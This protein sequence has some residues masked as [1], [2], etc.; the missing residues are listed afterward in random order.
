MS[1]W[2]LEGLRTGIKST[3]Y[4]NAPEGAAGISPGRPAS[5][6]I[7][8]QAQSP[9]PT[10]ALGAANGMSIVDYR[11]CVHCQRCK[12]VEPA[13]V[14]WQQD[15]EWA[16]KGDAPGIA[17]ELNRQFQRSLHIRFV[18]AGACGACM[19]EARQL[20]NPYYN[21]HRLGF[22]FTPTPRNA[23]VLMVTGPVTQAMWWPLLDTYAAIP[24]PKRVLAVGVC[25]ISGGVF[26][27]NPAVAGGAAEAI[28]IDV[29]VPGCPPPPLA[30][31]HG[32]LV[33]VRRKPPHPLTSGR[34][35]TLEPAT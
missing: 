17:G 21:M 4:P 35:P 18:D 3:R 11:K 33:L 25:A 13:I 32:L 34:Q 16:A 19:S 31:L 9:C 29:A 10:D 20:N 22:F 2:V 27:R 28:P 26:G 14:D 24:P 30:I 7:A 12:D 15:Y 8:A 1:R 5:R 23:D 6:V